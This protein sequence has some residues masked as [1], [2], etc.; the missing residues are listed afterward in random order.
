MTAG[1]Q[2]ERPSEANADQVN[3]L[4]DS[5]D[6]TRAVN[7]EEFR[8]FLDHIS[9]A[10]VISKFINGDQRICYANKAFEKLTGKVLED[11]CGQ[12]W[13]VL[14]AFK[15]DENNARTLHQAMREAGNDF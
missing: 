7:T 15:D 6:L 5:L 13:S 4:F 2:F 12:G 3:D 11:I 1:D 10:I 8:R 9:I 14:A